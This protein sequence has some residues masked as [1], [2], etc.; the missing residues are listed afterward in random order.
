MHRRF[1]Q[2]ALGDKLMYVKR[3]Q[4]EEKMQECDKAMR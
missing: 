1:K 4:L 3:R 2:V